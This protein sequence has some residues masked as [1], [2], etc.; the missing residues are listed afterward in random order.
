VAAGIVLS[1]LAGV[2]YVTDVQAERAQAEAARAQAEAARAQAEAA[3]AQAER[4]VNFLLDD[5]YDELWARERREYV[6]RV[7]RETLRYFEELPEPLQRASAVRMAR[8]LRNQGTV[9]IQ[10]GQF[11]AARAVYLRSLELDE[12]AAATAPGGDVEALAGMGSDLGNLIAIALDIEND[13]EAALTLVKRSLDVHTQL[14]QRQPGEVRWRDALALAWEFVGWSHYHQGDLTASRSGFE[15]AAELHRQLLAS[16]P[17]HRDRRF[18]LGDV[19]HM[20]GQAQY[21][22][23]QRDAALASYREGSQLLHA[24]SA[25]DPTVFNYSGFAAEVELSIGRSLAQKGDLSGALAALEKARM[26][27]EHNHEQ[28]PSRRRWSYR[29][30]QA[31]LYAARVLRQRGDVQAAQARLERAAPATIAD[32]SGL[33]EQGIWVEV[34]LELNRPEKTRP[35][36]E[37][38]V[39]RGWHRTPAH[40]EFS[41]LA[42]RHGFLPAAGAA[43]EP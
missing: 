17:S 11:Q 23:G 29:L 28:D 1:A 32:D 38:L 33:E 25:E 34:Q 4:L 16:E 24:L 42:Q 37:R 19:L 21:F 12:Q 20:L 15:H 3:R 27:F 31:H 43:P 5:L 2:K 10:Q 8:A 13:F 35:V 30:L 14:V 40:A 41:E 22:L 18:H 26:V 6:N 7:S 36:V 39:A 9:L